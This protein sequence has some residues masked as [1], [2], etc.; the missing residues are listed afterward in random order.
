[1]IQ[2]PDFIRAG[3]VIRQVQQAEHRWFAQGDP[4]SP[5]LPWMP[6]QPAEF[7]SILF[8]CVPEL[9]GREFLDVG[10]VDADSE[11]LAP[12][13]WHRI[14]DYAGGPVMQYES[15][16]GTGAFV[17]PERYIVKECPEFYELKTK[18]GLDQRLSP[19][20]RVLFWKY[21]GAERRKVQK[22]W[23]AEQFAAE[24]NR[25][26]N[27]V[28]GVFRTTFT[29]VLATDVPLTD[30]EI[31]VQVMVNADGTLRHGGKAHV[32]VLKQ[33]K[34]DRARKLLADA[35]ITWAEGVETDGCTRF[36]F[37]PPLYDKSFVPFWRAS[38]E[39]LAVIADEC[40]RWDGNAKHFSTRVRENAD[41]VQYAFTASGYRGTLLSYERLNGTDY[42][43]IRNDNTDVGVTGNPKTP[44]VK[45]PSQDGR[46]Y[47]FTVP[48]GF[49]VMRRGG[50]IVMTGNCGPGTKMLLA[51]HFYGLNARGIEISPEMA[52]EARLHGEV[53]TGDALHVPDGFYGAF[54]LVW[55]YRPFRDQWL[56][57]ELEVRV[58]K[59]M[60][61][62]AVLA[63]GAWELCPADFNWMPVVDDWE[64]RRGAWMKPR[65]VTDVELP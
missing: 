1:M 50:N 59:E 32:R 42:T 21:E 34:V 4:K 8:E 14:A 62:G 54:D 48:S 24:H 49:W 10:C 20:H 41:F 46:A 63:G 28:R 12:D 3:T 40:L 47:C 22:V 53:V 65:L 16:T 18:Y 51:G 36:S 64:L 33:R 37:K 30:A 27:G 58:M 38:A 2:V 19:D 31:R 15:S 39:Q 55:L 45:V 56:E 17:Q 25:L 23:S 57:N 35:D 26:S 60:K 6:F 61:P 11:Y 9:T 43:V 13:G 5:T 29:P 7:L 44:I 52:L